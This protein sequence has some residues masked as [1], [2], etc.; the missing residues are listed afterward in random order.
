V[1]R[2]FWNSLNVIFMTDFAFQLMAAIK[3]AQRQSGG[4]S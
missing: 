4:L 2:S 1:Y 3:E